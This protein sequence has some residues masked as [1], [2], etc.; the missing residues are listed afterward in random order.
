MSNGTSNNN[1]NK[2]NKNEGWAEDGSST[3]LSP[4]QS[5]KPKSSSTIRSPR[6]S[7]TLRAS[8]ITTKD[9]KSAIFTSLDSALLSLEQQQQQHDVHPKDDAASVRS[10][11]NHC[12]IGSMALKDYDDNE[13]DL[14]TTTSSS[15]STMKKKKKQTKRRSGRSKSPMRASKSNASLSSSSL[16]KMLQALPHEVLDQDTTATSTSTGTGTSSRRQSSK[17]KRSRRSSDDNK[18]VGSTKSWG[19]MLLALPD[20]GTRALKDDSMSVSTTVSASSSKQQQQQQRQAQR[21]ASRRAAPTRSKSMGAKVSPAERFGSSM[22]SPSS[23]TTATAIG[24]SSA[25]SVTGTTPKAKRKSALKRRKSGSSL[26]T[27][28][29]LLRG[30][31]TEDAMSVYSEGPLKDH[32]DDDDQDSEGDGNG[33]M[34]R[35]RPSLLARGLQALEGLYEDCA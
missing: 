30:S 25:S 7:R 10:E 11:I 17:G 33:T 4:K 29:T 27:M 3:L 26:T 21:R 24:T 18:S 12:K 2:N 28:A 5:R 14:L 35:R 22:V 20:E 32:G 8:E 34:R 23:G 16:G 31:A 15:S 6:V 19:D 13:E 9:R 1:N